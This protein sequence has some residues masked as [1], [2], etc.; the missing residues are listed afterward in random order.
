MEPPLY[1]NLSRQYPEVGSWPAVCVVYNGGGRD[2]PIGVKNAS[3]FD[4]E[5]MNRSGDRFLDLPGVHRMSGPYEFYCEPA[6]D[7]TMERA[8]PSGPYMVM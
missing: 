6:S 1:R 3:D 7:Q 2:T 4:L 8:E 5:I